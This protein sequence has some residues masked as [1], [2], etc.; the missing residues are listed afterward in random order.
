M[1]A[2]GPIPI[3]VTHLNLAALPVSPQVRLKWFV[4]LVFKEGI[5]EL[6]LDDTLDNCPIVLK[7]VGQITDMAESD[8]EKFVR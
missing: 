6:M 1:I 2:P 7:W 5:C 4:N 3:D 8:M